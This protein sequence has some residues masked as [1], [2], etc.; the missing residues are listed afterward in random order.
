MGLDIKANDESKNTDI[1]FT[2]LESEQ[3][4]QIKLYYKSNKTLKEQCEVQ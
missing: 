4:P 2:S 3:K 1:I